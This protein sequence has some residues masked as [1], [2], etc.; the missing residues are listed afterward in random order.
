MSRSYPIWNKVQACIYQSN[1]SYGAKNVSETTVCVGR[2]S[3]NSHELITHHTSRKET[4]D[5]VIFSFYIDGVKIKKAEF[6]K[7][8]RGEL[9]HIRTFYTKNITDIQDENA[10]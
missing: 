2:G 8:K 10:L 3:G 6:S 5:M 7:N 4:E 9:T 1:K